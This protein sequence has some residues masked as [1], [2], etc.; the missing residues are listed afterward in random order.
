[1]IARLIALL[2]PV[3]LLV[4]CGSAEP[5]EPPEPAVSTS[6]H[7]STVT[8]TAGFLA[9]QGLP[10]DATPVTREPAGDFDAVWRSGDISEE[11]A[12]L[13][14]E[15]FVRGYLADGATERAVIV[16]F[17]VTRDTETFHCAPDLDVVRC[18]GVYAQVFIA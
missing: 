14:R 4:A 5:P 17:P 6:V 18:V 9:E 2:L 12:R 15:E 3:G 16:Y 7:T 1:M 10:A 8:S 11:D 13:V